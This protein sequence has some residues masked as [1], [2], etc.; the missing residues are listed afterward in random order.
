MYLV[1]G[2]LRKRSF[3][4]NCG[5]TAAMAEFYNMGVLKINDKAITEAQAKAAEDLV[6]D[7]AGSGGEGSK[8]GGGSWLRFR[9]RLE[10]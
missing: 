3:D 5:S 2:F 8:G 9:L 1:V 6:K 7:K 10:L 4:A